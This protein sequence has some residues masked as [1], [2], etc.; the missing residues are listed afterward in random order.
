LFIAKT[1]LENEFITAILSCYDYKEMFL[2][3]FNH[4]AFPVSLLPKG[5]LISG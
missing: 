4:Y 3:Q 1:I 5:E 2:E